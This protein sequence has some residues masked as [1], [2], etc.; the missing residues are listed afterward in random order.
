MRKVLK[1]LFEKMVDNWSLKSMMILPVNWLSIDEAFLR[2]S[3]F[4]K[5]SSM[6]QVDTRASLILSLSV[7]ELTLLVTKRHY[8]ETSSKPF[9]FEMIYKEYKKFTQ[10]ATYSLDCSKQVVI[11]AFEHLQSVG[12]VYPADQRGTKVNALPKQYCKMYLAMSCRE[13]RDAVQS[14][15]NCPTDLQQWSSSTGTA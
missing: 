15:P 6:L 12:L 2:C 9:N 5:A 3:D 14:Y 8:M 11:S 7:L 13:V 4:H 1:M 10:E